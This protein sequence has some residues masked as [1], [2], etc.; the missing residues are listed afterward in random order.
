[1]IVGA[2]LVTLVSATGA[3]E[4][5]TLAMLKAQDAK[6]L[7][8]EALLALLPGAVDVSAPLRATAQQRRWSLAQDGR[9]TGNATGGLNQNSTRAE[10]KWRVNDDG[11]FC[12][13]IAWTWSG[14]SS[15]EK[16]CGLVYQAGSDH[17]VV[18]RDEPEAP[19]WKHKITR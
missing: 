5:M 17:Y 1:M 9:L 16:W 13:D 11:R 2:A 3:Q 14:G 15:E 19:A 8:K 6:R 10:G 18:F 4:K 7:D 12:V